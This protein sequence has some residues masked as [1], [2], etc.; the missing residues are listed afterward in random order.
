MRLE[1]DEVAELPACRAGAEE[2]VEADLE[3]VGGRRIT[4]D[5]AAELGRAAGLDAVGAHHH[6]Q[7]IPAHERGEALLHREIAGE[8]R[9][10]LERDAVDV[11][12]RHRRQPA[13]AAPAGVREQGVE[14]E[15]RTRL[16]VGGD[17]RVERFA[18]F[19]GLRR[20]DVSPPSASA[21]AMWRARERSVMV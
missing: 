9:L 12:R 7:R 1:E 13:Q 21:L 6:R 2:M 8:G 19:G 5:V 15:A 11:G 18:P 4:G 17:Q 16:A 10:R 20:I 3:Q 14:Q